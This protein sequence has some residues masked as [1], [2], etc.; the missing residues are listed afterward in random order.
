M[1]EEFLARHASLL[2]ESEERIDEGH[3]A[4]DERHVDAEAQFH[5]R[6]FKGDFHQ[7]G[8]RGEDEESCS[9]RQT[10]SQDFPLT[11]LDDDGAA[12]EWNE[13]DEEK[14]KLQKKHHQSKE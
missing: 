8:Q 12:E 13:R 10:E 7:N 3:D 2:L 4:T 1:S 5:P 6:E 11:F 14:G 9:R